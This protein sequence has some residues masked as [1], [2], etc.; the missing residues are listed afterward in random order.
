M[1]EPVQIRKLSATE[2]KPGVGGDDLASHTQARQPFGGCIFPPAFSHVRGRGSYGCIFTD[3]SGRQRK[4][5]IYMEVSPAKQ[6]LLHV[7]QDKPRQSLGLAGRD[8]RRAKA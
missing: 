1:R 2:R 5:R 4:R 7:Q 8:P 3:V 6:S